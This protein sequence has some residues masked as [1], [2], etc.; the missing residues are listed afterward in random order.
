MQKNKD[1]LTYEQAL[2]ELEAIVASLQQQAVSIDD[3]EQQSKRASELVRFC[4]ERL[5][6]ISKGLDSTF[7]L[8]E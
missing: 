8:K 4:K 3:L 5:R 1:A 2:T 6:H 7:E